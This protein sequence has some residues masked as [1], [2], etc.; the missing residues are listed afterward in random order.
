MMNTEFPAEPVPA[1]SVIVLRAH[2]TDASSSFEVLLIERAQ[3]AR[4]FA[5]A[6]VFPGGKVESGDAA[7]ALQNGFSQHWPQLAARITHREDEATAALLHHFAGLY[8]AAL[9]ETQEE[10]ALSWPTAACAPLQAFSRWITPKIPNMSVRRFDTLFFLAELPEGQEA[11]ADGN[12]AQRLV[13]GTPRQLLGRY[14]RGEVLLAPPQIMTL[15]HLSRFTDVQSVRVHTQTQPLPTI[16]PLSVDH[17]G[18]RI[19]CFPGDPL[20]SEA[21]AHMPGPTR[22]LLRATQR[23]EPEHSFDELFATQQDTGAQKSKITHQK[24]IIDPF[25]HD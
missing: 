5:G 16:E 11:R 4:N 21:K 1:A 23:F 6:L 17:L 20:H 19:V 12:E 9:R 24:K 3:Q 14:Q 8:G 13:W 2:H 10:V 15:A 22:L 25:R 18:Q 7:F